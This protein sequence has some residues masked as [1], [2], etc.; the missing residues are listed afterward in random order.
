MSWKISVFLAFFCTF[1][2]AED[3]NFKLIFFYHFLPADLKN[4]TY[5]LT[6]EEIC[7][8]DKNPRLANLGIED[9]EEAVKVLE[10]SL[11]AVVGRF[12][13]AF[14]SFKA[15]LDDLDEEAALVLKEVADKDRTYR[16]RMLNAIERYDRLS[17]YGKKSLEEHFPEIAK[18]CSD[19]MVRRM[20][21]RGK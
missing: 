11:P 6:P 3:D 19:E 17:F 1:V 14:A 13:E 7:K 18:S 12:E 21:G 8:M 16:Q 4:F 9:Y 15:K 20:V 5:K 2:I 10:E